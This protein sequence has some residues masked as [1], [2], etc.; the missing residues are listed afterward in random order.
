MGPETALVCSREGHQDSV[1]FLPR[2]AARQGVPGPAVSAAAAAAV[3]AAGWLLE[4][5][6][7]AAAPPGSS[8]C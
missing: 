7:V 3:A 5:F 4:G 2:R 1:P 6:L 8:I